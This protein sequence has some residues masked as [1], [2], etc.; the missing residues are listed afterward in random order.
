VL[1]ME[2][3]STGPYILSTLTRRVWLYVKT[4]W[5]LVVVV[6]GG[7]LILPTAFLLHS[8]VGTGGLARRRRS[9]RRARMALRHRRP[10]SLS[11]LISRLYGCSDSPGS[12]QAAGIRFLVTSRAKTVGRL[13]AKVRERAVS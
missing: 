3:P 13:E 10:R 9:T 4:A 7:A 1:R 12:L 8:G 11:T 6:I 2:V 5:L